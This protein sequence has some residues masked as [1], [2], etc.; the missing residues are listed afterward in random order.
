MKEEASIVRSL[1]N[2]GSNLDK[3]APLCSEEMHNSINKYTK[4]LSEMTQHRDQL[5]K[6]LADFQTESSNSV[7]TILL[8]EKNMFFILFLI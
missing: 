5:I 6:S 1:S 7:N 3:L 2:I 4:L 8:L